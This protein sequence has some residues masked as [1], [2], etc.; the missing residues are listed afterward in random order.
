MA[1]IR[2]V[3]D[4]EAGAKLG[5]VVNNEDTLKNIRVVLTRPSH[6][7][8]IGAAAR[9]MKTMGLDD[10]ALVQPRA[11]PHPEADTRARGGLDI[12][13]AAHLY[14]SLED[15]LAD[16]A[17]AIATSARHREMRHETMDVRTAAHAALATAR[18]QRVAIV[19]GNESTGLTAEEAQLCRLWAHIP[20]DDG[21]S[22]LN[23]ASA[24][25]VCAYELRMAMLAPASAEAEAPQLASV[26]QVAQ[27]HRQLVALM[28]RVGYHD[29]Q[30]PRQLLPRMRRLFARAQLEVD[31]VNIL[32]GFLKALDRER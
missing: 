27:L 3:A 2:R 13:R 14:D 8:N 23:L 10:L 5:I 1:K 18:S 24:V 11:F 4:D 29:P 22:S 26:A 32:R 17:Y 12:V 31:E 20:A 28:S 21:Y 6:P 7:G 25:Q 30:R 16:C 15:A 19:F 9:A